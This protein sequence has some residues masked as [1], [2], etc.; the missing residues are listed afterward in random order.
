MR[1]APEPCRTPAWLDGLEQWI[2]GLQHP[3]HGGGWLIGLDRRIIAVFWL[4]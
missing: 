3:Y 4:N 1:G 2:L